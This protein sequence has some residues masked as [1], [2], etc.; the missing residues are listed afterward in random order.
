MI[1]SANQRR[2][3]TMGTAA[4]R[5]VRFKVPGHIAEPLNAKIG[6]SGCSGSQGNQLK[7]FERR[8]VRTKRKDVLILLH[9]MRGGQPGQI[10]GIIQQAGLLRVGIAGGKCT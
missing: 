5:V 2:I 1:G 9:V 8:Q 3:Q 10:A 4:R 6:H 7:Y